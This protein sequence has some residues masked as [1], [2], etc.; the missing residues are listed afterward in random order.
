M[1]ISKYYMLSLFVHLFDDHL[2]RVNWVPGVDVSFRD[3]YCGFPRKMQKES[4]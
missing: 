2:L 1:C 4:S 3:L